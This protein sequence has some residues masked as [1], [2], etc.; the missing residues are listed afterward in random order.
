MADLDWALTELW[1]NCGKTA[2]LGEDVLCSRLLIS[3]WEE[4][5]EWQ[6]PAV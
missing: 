5:Q 6:F 3:P 4:Q 2:L 1:K